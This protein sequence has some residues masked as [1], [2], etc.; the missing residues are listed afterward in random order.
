VGRLLAAVVRA[1]VWRPWATVLLS[2]LLALGAGVYT[3]WTLDFLTSPLRLL[4][5]RARY[6]VLLKQYLE[7][8]AELDDIIVAVEAPDPDHAKRYADRLVR[9]LR[10]DGLESRITHRI[11]R[12][13]FDRRGLLYLSVDDLA[14]LRDRIFDYEEFI[15]NYAAWPTLARLLEGLNQQFANAMA[16]GFLDLG[17]G[18]DAEADLRF[19]DAVVDQILARLDESAP[20]V[21]PWD[22]GFSL[23]SL[24]DPDAGHYFSSDKRLLFLFVQ[25]RSD[26]GNFASNRERIEAIRHAIGKLASEFTDV[27]AGVTGGPT[28]ADDEMA[29]ALRDSALATGLAAVLIS[30]LLLV[31]YRRFGTPLLLLVTLAASLLWALGVIT[32]VVGHLSVF[33]VMFLSLVIGVGIDYGIYFLYR[34]QEE[35]AVDASVAEALERTADRTGPGM[36]LGA[37]TAAGAFFV[38]MLT[39]F[40]GIR[41][42][43][44]VSAVAILMAF[45][46]MVTLLPAL[47]MLDGRRP[48][49]LMPQPSSRSF[50]DRSES[51]WLVGLITC[52]KTILIVAGGLS[53]VGVWGVL[54]VT[55]D[56]NMLNL[57]AANVESV[58][59]E[60]RILASAGRSGSTALTTAGSVDELRRKQDALLRLPSVSEVESVLLLVPDEQPEK[61]RIIRQ[62]APVVAAVRVAAPPAGEPAALR[63]PLLVLRRRLGLAAE[64][65]TDE[66]VRASIQRL[67]QKVE[68][69]LA[70]FDRV[71]PDGVESLQRLQSVLYQD[72]KN[73][74]EQFQKSLD[75]QPVRVG[76][77]PPELRERYVGRSGRYLLR[78]HPA[79]DIWQ[80]DGARRFINDLRTVDRD[81]TG[82]PVT[83]FEATHLIERGYAEGTPYA[84][85]LVA[86]VTFAILR[87]LR[88]TALAL[89]PVGLGVLW[90]LG[91]MRLLGLEFNL[92]NVWALPLII[93]TAAEY[94]LNIYVRFL[95]GIGGG[96]P[97]FPRSVVS[98]VM[99]SWLTTIAGFGSLMV[100]HH[101]GIF[102]LG[103][104]LTLGSTASLVASLFLLPVLIGLFANRAV[105]R[106]VTVAVGTPDDA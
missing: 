71:G 10:D 16:L 35:W 23:G 36:L 6:V 83:K 26:E 77:A 39:D 37:L 11:D 67:R 100:A 51:E 1:S 92:A 25:E 94:G 14:R 46:A 104:L 45:L 74:L 24:D 58:I 78:I 86:T 57:Q 49:G 64:G 9:T 29:T 17:I 12:S 4:P 98:G 53:A 91:V 41:E 72:F 69:T 101:H 3:L 33:S 81:V 22:T 73:K 62:F 59:W 55:F 84:L 87:T 27:R 40:Q 52:R 95:E 18:G 105:A 66:R 42:F 50:R 70:R 89:A 65:V 54:G 15:R 93:G 90:T 48:P 76:E 43:G 31:A 75:P 106:P 2:L 20:Y 68:R 61:M 28:I 103:L 88:G 97:R 8:F 32:L 60:K 96:G 13:F 34:Y 80:K 5:Q 30:M 44:F 99:L 38:L 56:H 21:S 47:L 63:A 19:L 85:V 102:T 7:D 82:P 79:V